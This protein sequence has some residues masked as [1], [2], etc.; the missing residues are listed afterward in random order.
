MNNTLEQAILIS[1]AIR[2][3]SNAMKSKIFSFKWIWNFKKILIYAI[4]LGSRHTVIPHR[5]VTI[6]SHQSYRQYSVAGLYTSGHAPSH[7]ILLPVTLCLVSVPFPSHTSPMPASL[8]LLLCALL[9]K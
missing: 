5:V 6:V 3:Y 4:P 2:R 8:G 1:S 9:R 7:T